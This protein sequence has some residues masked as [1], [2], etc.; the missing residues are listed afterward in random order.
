M[1][2]PTMSGP[3]WG[4]TD[5]NYYD[6]LAYIKLTR[7]FEEHAWIAARHQGLKAPTR[8]FPPLTR[9]CSHRPRRI[10][11]VT[12]ARSSTPLLI[13]L[14]SL[15][16]ACMFFSTLSTLPTYSQNAE[17]G[18]CGIYQVKPSSEATTLQTNVVPTHMPAKARYR[19]TSSD[20]DTMEEL[21]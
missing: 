3:R 20:R 9:H 14:S 5:E 17:F 13:A 4:I 11:P 18:Y 21:T 15:E 7:M 8:P 2:P 12:G 1:G 19:S 10:R 16:K 6:T